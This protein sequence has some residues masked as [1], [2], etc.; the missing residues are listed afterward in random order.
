MTRFRLPAL[1]MGLILAAGLP[2]QASAQ[3]VPEAE[4]KVERSAKAGSVNTRPDAR[5]LNMSIPAPRG[6]I[7]DR[8]GEPLAQNR[9]AY[10]FAVQFE[11]FEEPTDDFIVAWAKQ[12]IARANQ[13]AETELVLPDEKLLAHYRD[14]RWLPLMFGSLIDPEKEGPLPCRVDS[15]SRHEPGLRAALPGE[16]H[17]CSQSSAMSAARGS[18]RP[19]RSTSANSSS[20]TPTAT[21]G[22]KSS[23]TTT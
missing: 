7:L 23:S 5:T 18:C 6:P 8:N 17:R 9:V 4:E 10:Y 13:L 11:Q 14:R 3:A 1:L 16:E 12:R 15:R 19:A 20:R 22:S 2:G 21:P